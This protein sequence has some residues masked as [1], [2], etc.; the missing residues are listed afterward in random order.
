MNQLSQLENEKGSRHRIARA[1]SKD[2]YFNFLK[3]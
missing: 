1:P 3:K 2:A